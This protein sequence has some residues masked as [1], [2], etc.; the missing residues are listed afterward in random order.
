M[1]VLTHHLDKIT[2][3][4]EKE[5]AKNETIVYMVNVACEVLGGPKRREKYDEAEF[6]PTKRQKRD[7]YT[8]YE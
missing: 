8:P 2:T 3:P 1:L 5:K 4:S 7:A 6:R